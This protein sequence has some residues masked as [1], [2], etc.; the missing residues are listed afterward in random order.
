MKY[1]E[2]KSS[3][4]FKEKRA[5]TDIYTVEARSLLNKATGFMAAYD[6]TLNPY[7]GCQY[8]CSYCYAAAFSPDEAKRQSWGDWV[9]IKANSVALLEKELTRWQK[10]HDRPPCIYMSS[11]T[12]ISHCF[13]YESEPR[14][15]SSQIYKQIFQQNLSPDGRVLLIIQ[16][17]KLFNFFDVS[18]NEDINQEKTVVQMFL[19]ELGLKLDWYKYFSSTEQRTNNKKQFHKF[20]RENLSPQ[21]QM[22][23]FSK[24]YLFQHYQSHY[25]VDDYVILAKPS[26]TTRI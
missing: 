23:N 16:G 24:T 15:R 2:Q 6:F 10:K 17:K 12:D 9:V 18:M 3:L 19:E 26:K 11:V 4:I 20:A 25:A 7:R 13:F 5:K 8:G 22:S 1:K 21:K 14:E